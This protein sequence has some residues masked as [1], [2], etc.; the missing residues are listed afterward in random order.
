LSFQGNTKPK[1]QYYNNDSSYYDNDY[2]NY[3]QRTQRKTPK[4]KVIEPEVKENQAS[5]NKKDTSGSDAESV[6]KKT[7]IIFI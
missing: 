7:I 1:K 5:S 6:R 3:P 2:Y 4:T